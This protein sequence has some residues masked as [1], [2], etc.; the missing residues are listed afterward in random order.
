MYYQLTAQIIR[1][2]LLS[3]N[4]KIGMCA[5]SNVCHEPEYTRKH[6]K[7]GSIVG[8]NPDKGNRLYTF[9]FTYC[10]RNSY[11]QGYVFVRPRP[12]QE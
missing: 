10:C 6:V 8:L 11:F 2:Q 7:N 3:A 5:E 4:A 9:I 12:L 1:A